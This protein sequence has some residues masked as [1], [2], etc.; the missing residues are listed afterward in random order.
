MA[1]HTGRCFRALR[2]TKGRKARQGGSYDFPI[3]HK[4]PLAIRAFLVGDLR[5][6]H[7][8]ADAMNIAMAGFAK[9]QM[10]VGGKVGQHAARGR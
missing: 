4:V 9:H 2:R 1:A 7:A 10:M 6:R 5:Q 8:G 3:R